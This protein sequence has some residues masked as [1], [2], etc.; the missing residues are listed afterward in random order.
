MIQLCNLNLLLCNSDSRND[1]QSCHICSA[2]HDHL[3]SEDLLA[4]V[5]SNLGTADIALCEVSN[6]SL[7][8][9]LMAMPM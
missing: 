2:I 5:S 9:G 4:D 3:T 6:Y 8:E 1:K 7:Y